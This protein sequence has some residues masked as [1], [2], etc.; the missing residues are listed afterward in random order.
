MY[1]NEMLITQD[2]G[3]AYQPWYQKLFPS[4]GAVQAAQIDAVTS[5]A[6]E[7]TA[8]DLAW[9]DMQLWARDPFK[10]KG[11]L[12]SGL[13]C[14]LCG[15]EDAAQSDQTSGND[16]STPYNVPTAA[17]VSSSDLSPQAFD[18]LNADLAK[19]YGMS[20][21]TAYQE[22]LSNTSYQRAVK[23]MQAAGLN[24]A[25]IF[26]AGR[27]SGSSGVSYVS[28]ESSAGSGGVGRTTAKKENLFSEG[29]YYGLSAGI[30][31]LAGILTKSPT[32]YWI[33]SQSAQGFMTAV[34]SV[35]KNLK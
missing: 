34:N 22:A 1:R 31:L 12:K 5:A 11:G 20:K 23:D 18:F 13:L 8:Q 29:A 27:G 17:G 26:G 16:G 28:S 25:A 33:G 15:T 24:P 7:V 19:H 21:E 3:L 10:Y 14:L 30:G 35:W 32:G 4:A 9:H 2:S 6:P